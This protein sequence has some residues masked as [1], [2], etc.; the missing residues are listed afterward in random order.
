[1]I[2]LISCSSN[3]EITPVATHTVFPTKKPRSTNTPIETPP[4]TV[5]PTVYKI[6]TPNVTYEPYI[7]ESVVSPNGEY[8]AY[9]Y[10]F[11]W[12]YHQTVEIKDKDG[13]VIWQIPYQG[14]LPKGDPHPYMNIHRWS[15]DSSKLYFCYYWAP[16]GGDDPFISSCYNLQQLDL[17]TGEVRSVQRSPDDDDQIVYVSCQHKLCI[18]HVQNIPT[19]NEK[20]TIIDSESGN[21][22]IQTGYIDWH[23]N[24][25]GFIDGSGFVFHLQDSNYIV[26]TIYFNMLTMEYKVIKKYPALDMPGWAE[27][28]GWVD[29]NTLEFLE[30]G[31]EGVQVVYIDVGSSETTVMGTPTPSPTPSK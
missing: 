25:A 31:I 15:D 1:M 10:D 13:K 6:I 17:K 11:Y 23:L 3:S 4:A 7:I 19:G 22:L 21:N 24:K 9:A 2:T 12:N 18:V 20:I 29:E 14:E 30:S 5:A 26:Q 27:F 16:D 8:V 28:V